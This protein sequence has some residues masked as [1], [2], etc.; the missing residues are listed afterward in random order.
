MLQ[1][2]FQCGWTAG[3]QQV[4]AE[5]LYPLILLMRGQAESGGKGEDVR[6]SRTMD[7]ASQAFLFDY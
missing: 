5:A 2:L 4:V 6:L 3:T 1:G 7:N